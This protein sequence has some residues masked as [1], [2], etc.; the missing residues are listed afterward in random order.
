MKDTPNYHLTPI[1]D[2]L[3]EGGQSLER[4]FTGVV[5][6]AVLEDAPSF[7]IRIHIKS[8]SY[9][10]QCSANLHVWNPQSLKWS[11][12]CYIPYS[13][14]KTARSLAY[15]QPPHRTR[16]EFQADFDA[17]MAEA[18]KILF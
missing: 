14:M 5:K 17:L 1:S 16:K 4:I 6:L 8:D 10:S 9:D 7:K 15:K 18:V 3:H 13:N 2:Q 11:S 12:V